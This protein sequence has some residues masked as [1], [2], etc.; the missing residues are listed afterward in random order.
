MI[1]IKSYSISHAELIALVISVLPMLDREIFRLVFHL[2][3]GLQV[4]CCIKS[5]FW[6]SYSNTI[7]SC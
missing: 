4:C 3:Q 7:K 1:L 2:S 5:I 6:F